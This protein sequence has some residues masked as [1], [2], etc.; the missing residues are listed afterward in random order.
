MLVFPNSVPDFL[1]I[2]TQFLES[3]RIEGTG[4]KKQRVVFAQSCIRTLEH[5]KQGMQIATLESTHTPEGPASD[6]ND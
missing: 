1:G 2:Q 5:P 6:W 3:L 4:E